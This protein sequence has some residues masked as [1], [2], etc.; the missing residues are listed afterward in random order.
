MG[1]TFTSLVS[2]SAQNTADIFENLLK[3]RTN[4]VFLNLTTKR[5]GSILGGSI[6]CYMNA[7]DSDGKS[8]QDLTSFF[9]L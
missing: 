2:K 8:F 3:R 1:Q 7:D 4:E 5:E 9:Y 6:E